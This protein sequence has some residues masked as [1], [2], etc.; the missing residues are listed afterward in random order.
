MPA[1][2]ADVF[3]DQ[4]LVALKDKRVLTRFLSNV[5]AA[6]EGQGR[7]KVT[8]VCG[9]C[10]CLSVA[11]SRGGEYPVGCPGLSSACFMAEHS[12]LSTC[13]KDVPLMHCLLP[14]EACPRTKQQGMH[15][16]CA[17]GLP[18]VVPSRAAHSPCLQASFDGR[19]VPLQRLQALPESALAACQPSVMDGQWCSCQGLCSVPVHPLCL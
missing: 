10:R 11:G 14:C 15:V 17:L 16:H 19:P 13:T 7:L 9:M 4:A 6:M 5:A 8:I 1:S 3:R 12:L 2:R 18:R